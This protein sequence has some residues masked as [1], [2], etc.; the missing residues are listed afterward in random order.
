MVMDTLMRSK[1]MPLN[2]VRMSRMESMAT[3]AIPTSPRTRSWSLS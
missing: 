1:G 2:S 3:P